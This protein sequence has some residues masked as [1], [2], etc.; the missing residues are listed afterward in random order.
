MSRADSNKT[1]VNGFKDKH[2]EIPSEDGKQDYQSLLKTTS[3]KSGR[4]SNECENLHGN[5]SFSA[6]K[7]KPSESQ[8]FDEDH[9]DDNSKKQG[10]FMN[11]NSSVECLEPKKAK[12]GIDK[13]IKN[14]DISVEEMMEKT[15]KERVDE[16]V[17]K[18]EADPLLLSDEEEETAGSYS[19]NTISSAG[20]NSNEMHGF[21]DERYE[22]RNKGPKEEDIKRFLEKPGSGRICPEC[23]HYLHHIYFSADRNKPSKSDESDDNGKKRSCSCSSNSSSE[24]LETKK[25]KL[26]NDEE[27]DGIVESPESED[28]MSAPSPKSD[29]TEIPPR[30]GVIDE[31]DE[32]VIMKVCLS[33]GR[34]GYESIDDTGFEKGF[35]AEKIVGCIMG[36]TGNMVVLVKWKGREKLGYVPAAIAKRYVPQ[37]MLNFYQNN[38]AWEMLNNEET[39]Q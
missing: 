11:S 35:E 37:L 12:L 5:S 20:L 31:S 19:V 8:E 27:M 26:D 10:F 14:D 32:R 6:N 24:Y 15:W 25:P 3:L 39:K 22:N 29:K 38:I 33:E 28:G 36:E 13:H 9:F 4:T 16:W 2:N 34:S 18:V 23:E 1:E 17:H 7:N 30:R 21:R